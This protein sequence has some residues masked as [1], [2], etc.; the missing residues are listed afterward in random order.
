[1]ARIQIGNATV[2]GFVNL[3]ADKRI[4][5]G[6]GSYEKEGQKVFKES[7]TVFLDDKFDGEVPAK[8]DY[9][10][11]N[12]DLV[13]SNRKDKPDELQTT[14]NIRFKNQLTKKD[15]PKAKAP[16]AE[17]AGGGDI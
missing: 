9:V 15:A 14:V 2:S 13:I 3:V 11:V 17:S 6:T 12:G 5:V 7:V 16:A 1:M 10:Q 8:G 4:V